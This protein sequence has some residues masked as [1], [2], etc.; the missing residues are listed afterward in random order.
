MMYHLGRKGVLS[1]PFVVF[2]S[3][4][5]PSVDRYLGLAFRLNYYTFL[6][7]FCVIT[8]HYTTVMR[9]K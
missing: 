1:L 7:N 3:I 2:L 9:F 5:G 4:I 8:L 6:L